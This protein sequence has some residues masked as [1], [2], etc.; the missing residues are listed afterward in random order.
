[1]RWFQ[2]TRIDVD[3][4]SRRGAG[5]EAVDPARDRQ[6]VL[7]ARAVPA[8]GYEG[9]QPGVYGGEAEGLCRLRFFMQSSTQ[10]GVQ[11]RRVASSPAGTRLKSQPNIP[12][13]VFQLYDDSLRMVRRGGGQKSCGKRSVRALEPYTLLV[14]KGV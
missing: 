4:R 6:G 11:K 5:H 14:H 1:M 10:V 8:G 3:V 7:R 9:P 13:Y 2:R 12:I